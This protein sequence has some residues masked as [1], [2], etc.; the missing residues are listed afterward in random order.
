MKT[1]Q[2]IADNF[3]N[4]TTFHIFSSRFACK[5]II[6]KLFKHFKDIEVLTFNC[7]HEFESELLSELTDEQLE[8]I[9]TLELK[10]GI[11]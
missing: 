11:R 6:R 9:K 10:W 2:Y 3:R 1:F 8:N 5:E 4:L 7:N